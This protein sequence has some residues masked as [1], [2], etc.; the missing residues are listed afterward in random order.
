MNLSLGDERKSVMN[1]AEEEHR[2]W[3]KCQKSERMVLALI[4]SY[5]D[6]FVSI[7]SL[8]KKIRNYYIILCAWVLCLMYVYV[9]LKICFVFCFWQ[10]VWGEVQDRNP[11]V[12]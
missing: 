3:R 12:D 8:I 4:T 1:G 2:G 10:G 7:V 9:P 6:R 5:K 11:S